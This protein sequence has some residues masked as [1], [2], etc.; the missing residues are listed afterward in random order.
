MEEASGALH[1]AESQASQKHQE[2]LNLQRNHEAD[3]QMAISKAVIQY[4]EQ[5]SMAKHN[6]QSKDCEHRQAVQ[7]LQDQVCALELSL[8]SQENL[9]SVRHSQDGVD[10]QEE[11]FNYLPGNVNTNWGAALYK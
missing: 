3:I 10:L 4:K 2:L 8:A 7:K 6:L 1:A 5:L 11:V 9:P